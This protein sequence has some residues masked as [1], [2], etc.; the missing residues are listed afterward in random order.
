L[1]ELLLPVE[2]QQVEITAVYLSAN[3]IQIGLSLLLINIKV[4][5]F[6]ISL[7]VL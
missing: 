2:E 6:I 3:F 5:L 1:E 4:S 7:S